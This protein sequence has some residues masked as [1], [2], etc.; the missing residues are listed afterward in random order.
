MIG[1]NQSVVT[2]STIPNSVLN[3]RWLALSYHRVRA[4]IAHGI[5]HFCHVD[6]ANN[7]A[8]FLTK[9]LGHNKF[10]PLVQPLLFMDDNKL[11]TSV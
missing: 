10:W 7:V 3:K 11:N 1:D 9:A 2:S 6:S 8:D 5:L 4:A